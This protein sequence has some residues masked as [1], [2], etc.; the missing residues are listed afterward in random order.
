[1][2]IDQLDAN[3]TYRGY[4]IATDT[5]NNRFG[6]LHRAWVDN[7]EPIM[8]LK[9]YGTRAEAVASARKTIDHWED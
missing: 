9:A 3:T 5:V 7:G 6:T 4:T 1:M 2:T 8:D